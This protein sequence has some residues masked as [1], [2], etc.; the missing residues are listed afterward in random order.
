MLKGEARIANHADPQIARV[1][2]MKETPVSV[3]PDRS[4]LVYLG[5][6]V[7]A[8]FARL[9]FILLFPTTG[10]DADVYSTVAQNI[11][12]GC[13]VSLSDPASGACI[14]HFGGNQGPGYPFFMAAVWFLS[15]H[16]D[17][18]VRLLQAAF[19]AG[20]I[21]FAAY[22]LATL[23]SRRAGTV[24]GLV[25]ALSPLELAWPRY[26]QTETLSLAAVICFFALVILSIRDKRMH[27]VAIGATLAIGTFIRLDL[28]S[29]TIPVAVLA[30]ALYDVQTALARGTIVAIIL[31]IPWAGWTIRNVAV[32]LPRLYPTAM[33]VP[34][35]KRAPVGYASWVRT[36]LV[37][38]YE[39]PGALWG[40]NRFNYSGIYIPDR[41][42]NSKKEK[43]EVTKLLERLKTYEG[44]PI[45]KDIDDAFA[46]IAREQRERY[47]FRYFVV[48]PA[49]R[50]V[51]LWSNPFS[52]FGWPDEMPS[53]ALSDRERLAVAQGGLQGKLML[54]K[55]FPIRAVAKAITGLYR[56]ALLAVFLLGCLY[57]A[58]G[59]RDRSVRILVLTAFS[60]FAGRTLLLAFIANIETRYTVQLVPAMEIV[61]VSLVWYW[62]TRRPLAAE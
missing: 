57:A 30:F 16:S 37:Y 8:F 7:L 18:A 22:A 3:Q 34:D 11:I 55:R 21:G 56:F 23:T 6:A 51:Q 54:A 45:P 53:V 32:G 4:A 47:P 43:Q 44:Q 14:P 31:A 17:M 39:R 60:F 25:L 33:T 62:F 59:V 27:I 28:V 52:S 13:G 38:E 12:S 50:S 61:V 15:S 1:R 48:N 41:A 36:W 58:F 24:L 46:Q 49:I 5:V 19:L 29:L 10:G 35:N 2:T 40:P 20:A 9:P 26:L 42:Y